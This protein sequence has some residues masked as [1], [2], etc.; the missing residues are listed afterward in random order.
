MAVGCQLAAR[1]EETT[2]GQE[3]RPVSVHRISK[4]QEM[5][6]ACFLMLKA[7]L[8]F[9]WETGLVTAPAVG[10]AHASVFAASKILRV[11]PREPW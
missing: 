7:L 10:R 1:G 6:Q 8:F 2:L 3:N 9:L 5:M 4:A 11:F